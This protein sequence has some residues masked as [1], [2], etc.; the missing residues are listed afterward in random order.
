M[1]HGSVGAGR[2]D[3]RLLARACAG[4]GA[5]I[6]A[7]QEVDRRAARSGFADQVRR[8][9]RATGLSATFGEAARRGPLRRYGNVLLA[10]GV[11]TEVEVVGLPR[12]EQGEYR[13][14]VLARLVLDPD[15]AGAEG[16]PA[17][18]VAATHLSFRRTEGPAQLAAVVELLGRRPLPRVLLGD[19]NLGPEVVE[20][21]LVT[22]GYQVA[23]T[24]PTFPAHAPRTRIDYVAVAGLEV[25]SARAPEAALS[26]HRP[27]VAEVTAPPGQSAGTG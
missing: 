1:K 26:D 18:S 9:A 2:V 13:V 15:L 3:N 10:R 5:D 23:A 11:L 7:L 21:A 14:V 16:V 17:L 25:V 6:L 12:P 22:S 8:V 27:V 4:L 20:P 19:L 24:G